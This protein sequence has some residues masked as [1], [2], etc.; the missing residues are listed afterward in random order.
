M[1]VL[2][3]AECA[4]RHCKN[5]LITSTGIK[6]KSSTRTGT[7]TRSGSAITRN[8][9]LRVRGLTLQQKS[10]EPAYVAWGT[11]TKRSV[12]ALITLFFFLSHVTVPDHELSTRAM[13]S[14]HVFN[15]FEELN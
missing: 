12:P 10:H 14:D 5:C 6:K 1:L 11:R 4:Y 15:C 7:I 2:V 3:R 9:I 8:E 13:F